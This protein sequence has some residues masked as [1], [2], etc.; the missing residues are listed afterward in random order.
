MF[1]FNFSEDFVTGFVK[2]AF[3]IKVAAFLIL[4]GVE[5]VY[6]VL[7]SIEFDDCINEVTLEL[8]AKN[9]TI[10]N[11]KAVHY[12]EGGDLVNINN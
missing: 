9:T 5:S 3:A 7:E 4:S 10:P 12:C 8:E 1:G 6:G 2:T 11:A